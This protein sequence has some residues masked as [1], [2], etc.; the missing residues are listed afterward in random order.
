MA[1]FDR[2]APY[3]DL[4]HDG[5]PGEAE[6]YV[7]QAVRSGGPVLELGAGTG[8]LAIPMTM[9]GIKVVALDNAAEM[10]MVLGEKAALIGPMAGKVWPVAGDMRRF[11]LKMQFPFIA[12]AYRTFMHLDS[13]EDQRACLAAVARHLAPEGH[14]MLNVWHATPERLAG[15][16]RA[17]ADWRIE[18]VFPLEGG[19][20]LTHRHRARYDVSARRMHEEHHFLAEG[21]PGTEGW[22]DYLPLVRTW[23]DPPEMISLIEEAGMEVKTMFSD[24]ACRPWHDGAEEAIFVCVKR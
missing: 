15:M 6:F 19:I 1:D 13:I 17:Q 7:G 20:R 9:S 10:L 12:M 14:F 11:Q 4:V 21:P 5:L 24:F 18:G 3:Y 22:E 2:W 16:A 23:S 8:R